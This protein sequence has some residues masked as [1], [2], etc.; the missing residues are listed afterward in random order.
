[1]RKHPDADS[2]KYYYDAA[3][4]LISMQT[5]ELL[6]QSIQIDYKYNYNKLIEIHYPQNRENNVY[7]KYG[8]ASSGNQAARITKQQD[9]SGVQEFYYGKMGELKQNSHTFVL[10]E[11]QNNYTFET[12]WQYDSWNRLLSITYPDGEELHYEYNRGGLLRD[13]W[14]KKN[15]S[16]YNFIDKIVYN[17]FEKRLRVDYNNGV[18]TEYGYNPQNLQLSSLFTYSNSLGIPLQDITYNYDSVENIT[19]IKNTAIAYNGMGGI[20]DYF[21]SYDKLYRLTNATGN[22]NNS[23][24]FD[25][26]MQYSASGNILNKRQYAETN[27]NNN[28]IL[29]N[30]DNDYYYNTS[31]PHEVININN[32]KVAS[33]KW[34]KN[35]NLFYMERN[36][37][38]LI[39]SQC[40]DEENRLK[41]VKDDF[42]FSHYTY[43]AGG[44]R[45]L[46]RSG[47][48]QQMQI[49]ADQIVDFVNITDH[50]LYVNPYLTIN[51]QEYT[52]HYFTEGQ[53]V[54]SKLG[55]GF[56][57]INI[58]YELDTVHS[59]YEEQEYLLN[60]GILNG[61][62]C[63]GLG[64]ENITVEPAFHQ[65]NFYNNQNENDIYYYHSDHLGSSSYITDI[66]GSPTQHLQYLPYGELFIE[67][68]NTASYYTP[69]KFSAKEKDEETGYSYF[70]ARYLNTDFSI[71]LSV[72]P[73]SDDYPHISAYN[74][75]F[76]N[77]INLIDPDGRA[78]GSPSTHT[79]EA[80]NVIA[81]KNDGDLG[82]YKHTGTGAEDMKTY[83]ATNT[84][85]GGTKMGE[86]ANWDEF[87]GHSQSGEISENV[88]PGAKIEFGS[89]WDKTINE[90]HDVAKDMN[91]KEI[92]NE[93]L[94]NKLF[95]IKSHLSLAKNGA[96]TGKLLDGKYA[97]AESAGNYLAGYNGRNAT[98]LGK[99][100]SFS[101]YMR[102]A[103]A[104]HQG[105]WE[106]SK[107]A[108][109]VIFGAV[110]Y[111]SSP[112]F[113]EIEHAGRMIKSGWN[114]K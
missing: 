32:D 107:T 67:Q 36:S 69:Y 24:D 46:K 9:A 74:Y 81:V 79:D 31:K 54:C 21:Y 14:S 50:T 58:E 103:G 91:L 12:R 38:G 97:T 92:A 101:A 27:I 8:D 48:V 40:W 77:P 105:K 62:G 57:N 5:Q 112:W 80:G 61:A 98:L 29:I 42:N 63:T 104:V 114:K 17:K 39:R 11:N 47:M 108:L 88:M 111:G 78:A 83:S 41:A 28:S 4:N 16:T 109:N 66:N 18:Y 19:E 26:G 99:H 96:G 113:G 102:L 2:T 94:P 52:K 7:Y 25:L 60:I 85:A 45:V 23:N 75:C 87:R 15:G 49:N 82:V 3:G 44:E 71:W 20:Y 64:K 51:E 86:T 34:D 76:N 43:D 73:M 84:S 100:I 10:P 6:N 90:L 70:G 72:D 37:D 33:F 65:V 53:R 89:S 59:T 68:R 56:T 13:M 30:Y 55:G 35:G 106:G 22:F 1:M 110:S 95:D 93:S